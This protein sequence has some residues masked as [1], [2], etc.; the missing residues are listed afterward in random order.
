MP[1]IER[2]LRELAD[3]AAWPPTPDLAAAVTTRL[4]AGPAHVSAKSPRS[5]G[6]R[7]RR[8]VVALLAALVVTVPAAAFALPG[9]R[10]AI[11]E[12]LGLRHVTVEQRPQL[13]AG[14]AP[15]LGARTTLAGAPRLAGFVPRVPAALGPPDRVFVNKG[16][17]TLQY[18]PGRLLLA[19]ARGELD[20]AILGKIVGVDRR[21]QQVR[22]N[23]HPGI[24][25]AAPHDYFWTDA[26]GPPVRSGPALVWEQD[27]LVLRL[28]GARSPAAARRIAQSVP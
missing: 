5:R 27:G 2:A 25:L 4:S 3:D 12:T 10:R 11:L 22:V 6:R 13:P 9:P 18:E 19:Q 20:R 21:I 26:T 7:P 28:E 15:R 23:G 16:I 1:D 8:L 14:A 24:Y 17:V